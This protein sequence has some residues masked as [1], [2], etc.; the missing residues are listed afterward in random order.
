MDVCKC[1][2]PLRQGGTINSR[3]AAN[4]LVK[5]VEGEERWETSDQP[6]G[7]L[8]QNW[9]EIQK[10][11]LSQALVTFIPSSREGHDDNNLTIDDD[12]VVSMRRNQIRQYRG[13]R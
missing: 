10:F 4:P 7:V 1:I 11:N 6:Q 2:V 3:R 13:P 12:P 8:P 9:G 5:L